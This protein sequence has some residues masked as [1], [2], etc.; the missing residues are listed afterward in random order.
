[1]PLSGVSPDPCQKLDDPSIPP[2]GGI[3][4]AY[5]PA[6]PHSKAF[7][8]LEH[9][10]QLLST[11]LFLKKSR[12]GMSRY[13]VTTL[14]K[15]LP[16]TSLKLPEPPMRKN[17]VRDPITDLGN[18]LCPPGPLWRHDR[19]SC[20]RSCRPQPRLCRLHQIQT[21]VRAYMLEHRAAVQQQLVQQDA[22]G[23][24]R[25]HLDREKVL[26]RLWEIATLSPEMTP[27]S[28]TGQVK[29]LSMIVAIEGLIPDRS[30]I[31]AQNN[32]VPASPEPDICRELSWM[33]DSMKRKVLQPALG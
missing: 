9:T 25:L 24:R 31:S 11:W 17:I 5:H 20:R 33:R 28:I 6:P 26:N 29:A 16:Q 2:L 7:S 4:Y 19:P 10:E 12:T 15:P 3:F 21:R 32:S 27:G 22:D 1:L 23:Q 18:S 13:G 30:A 14:E 8:L